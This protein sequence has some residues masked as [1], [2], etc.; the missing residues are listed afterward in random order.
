M[1][2]TA[3]HT[4]CPDVT[5]HNPDVV[6]RERAPSLDGTSPTETDPK[7]EDEEE[8]GVDMHVTVRARL[9]R[10]VLQ[11]ARVATGRLGGG[12]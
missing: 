2:G 3:L 4:C 12:G 7:G 9:G 11:A 6:S 10:L 8:K 1:L 5:A